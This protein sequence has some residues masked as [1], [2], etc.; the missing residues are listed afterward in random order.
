[1]TPTF[2]DHCGPGL[3]RVDFVAQLHTKFASPQT[4]TEQ[5]RSLLGRETRVKVEVRRLSAACDCGYWHRKQ[6]PSMRD[7]DSELTAH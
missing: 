1:M 5:L 3:D 6:H 2:E 4:L 7:G